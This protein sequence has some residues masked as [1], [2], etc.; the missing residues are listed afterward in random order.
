MATLDCATLDMDTD[1]EQLGA[2]SFPRIL[3]A[4]QATLRLTA[5]HKLLQLPTSSKLSLLKTILFPAVKASFHPDTDTVD[6]KQSMS[7]SAFA[8]LVSLTTLSPGLGR[9]VV[10][11]L[12]S[13]HSTQNMEQDLQQLTQEEERM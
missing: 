7:G 9:D 2:R 1:G 6:S 11:C 4:K 10:S 12:I 3:A 13:L 5:A 8:L